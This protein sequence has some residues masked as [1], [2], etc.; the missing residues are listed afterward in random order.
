MAYFPDAVTLRGL[1]HLVELK[2]QVK[3]GDRC[4]IF[5]LVQR[6]DATLFSPAYHIDP[7]YSQALKLAVDNGVEIMAYDVTIDLQKMYLN[8][9]LPY[10]FKTHNKAP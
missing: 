2:Q 5:F 8:Q 1:K 9:P 4:T 6:T 10:I 3:K 7:S